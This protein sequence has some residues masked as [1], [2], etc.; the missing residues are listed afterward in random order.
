MRSCDLP[1]CM[2]FWQTEN[3]KPAESTWH[4]CK[5]T[6][7]VSPTWIWL[8]KL[9][10][11]RV[12]RPPEPSKN[13][14]KETCSTCMY[15]RRNSLESIWTKWSKQYF[16][17]CVWEDKTTQVMFATNCICYCSRLKYWCGSLAMQMH[18]FW[19]MHLKK[20]CLPALWS[21]GKWHIVLC[22]HES[23]WS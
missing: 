14:D 7:Y 1:N 18:R 16:I 13:T 2:Q 5:T 22:T 8:C 21:R 12:L 6:I 3:K 11:R 17:V 9:V 4:Q 15:R 19:N 20:G 23:V 10:T